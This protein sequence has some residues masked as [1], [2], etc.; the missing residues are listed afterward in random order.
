MCQEGG[1]ST[2]LINA[3]AA[4]LVAQR[5]WLVLTIHSGSPVAAYL[6]TVVLQDIVRSMALRTLARDQAWFGL[7][8]NRYGDGWP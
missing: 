7:A 2:S 1:F 3:F 5:R 8:G 4:Y 6:A